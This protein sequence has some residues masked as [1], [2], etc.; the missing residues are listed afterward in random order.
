MN[1]KSVFLIAWAIAIVSTARLVLADEQQSF[2]VAVNVSG[3]NEAQTNLITSYL[4]RELRALHDVEVTDS[5][6]TYKIDIVALTLANRGNVHTGNAISI[7]V[8]LCPGDY[9]WAL[10]KSLNAEYRKI[11]ATTISK[12]V[13]IED[14]K[15]I[16]GA[17]DDLPGQMVRFVAD[18][19]TKSL[20][21]ARDFAQ[22]MRDIQKSKPT[23]DKR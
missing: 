8:S 5:N 18:F 6:P 16:V 19:D 14:D 22:K 12:M 3:E 1:V 9:E 23:Q 21:P 15:L 10:S 13:T 7:L 2:R 11:I 4:T 17:D 20:Q